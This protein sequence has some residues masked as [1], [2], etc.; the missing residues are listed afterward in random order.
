MAAH[1]TE[2]RRM[3]CLD[4]FDRSQEHKPA[5]KTWIEGLIARLSAFIRRLAK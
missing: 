3:S 1:N 4:Q 2:P 5:Y